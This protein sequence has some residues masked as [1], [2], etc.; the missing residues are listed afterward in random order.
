MEKYSLLQI[1]FTAYVMKSLDNRK[2]SFLNQERNR[3][4]KDE[5]CFE[6]REEGWS[7]FDDQFAQYYVEKV[8]MIKDWDNTFHI[9][10]FLESPRLI[11]ALTRLKE[12]ERKVFLAK[13]LGELS[14]DEIGQILNLRTKQAEMLYYYVLR[15]LRR[16]LK[17]KD[18]V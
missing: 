10:T 14:F 2:N 15:K 3:R 18:E 12:K 1:K 7:N 16:E 17:N 8:G 5:L 4:K 6:L 11:K 9:L 13:A